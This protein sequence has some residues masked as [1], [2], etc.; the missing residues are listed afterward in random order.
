M[1]ITIA[2]TGASGSVYAQ[3]LLDRLT[4]CA[5]VERITLILSDSARQVAEHETGS[6][7]YESLCGKVIREDCRNLFSH[8]ASGSGC[9]DAMVVVP[10]SMGTLGRISG[11]ISDTLIT[12]AADVMLKE[13]KKLILVPRETPYSLIH[14]ENMRSITLAGGV[15]LPACPSFYAAATPSPQQLILSVVE[16]IE[17]QLGLSIPRYRWGE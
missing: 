1:T 9:D 2:V 13:R 16:R 8:A 10:C 15:I 3:T 6:R 12:R 14:I 17:A 7:W 5:E 11:G 4:R